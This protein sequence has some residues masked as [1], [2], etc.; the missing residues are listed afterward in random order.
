[1]DRQFYPGLENEGILIRN[2]QEKLTFIQEGGH[3][4]VHIRHKIRL[5]NQHV[6][7]STQKDNELHCK[8]VSLFINPGGFRLRGARPCAIQGKA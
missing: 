8:G 5:V 7:V 2:S 3:L 1:M 4:F 6:M